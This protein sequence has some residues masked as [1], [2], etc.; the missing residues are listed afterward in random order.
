M[1]DSQLV[2]STTIAFEKGGWLTAVLLRGEPGAG[3]SDLALRV[4]D[5]GRAE[6]VSDDQTILVRQGNKLLASAPS[7]IAGKLEVRGLGIVS[8]SYCS[9]VPVGL[10][11]D[12][13]SREEVERLPESAREEILGI[14]IS[15]MRLH[16]FDHSTVAK[17]LLAISNPESDIVR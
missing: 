2:H 15:R 5:A 3:K 16:S 10:I 17:L 9:D 8:F 12:L 7:T 6:L 1:S 11:V 4:I 13:V 14:E